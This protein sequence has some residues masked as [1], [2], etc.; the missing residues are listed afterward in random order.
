MNGGLNISVLD[1]WWAEAY[2]GANGFAIGN[3]S[4]HAN[5]DRQDQIDV[6]SLYNVLENEVV[7]LFYDRDPDGVP[8]GWIARQKHALR[9]L[10][11]R[12]SSR[13]MLIDYTL[14]CYLPA[15]GGMTSST[16][17]DIRLLGETFALPPFAQQPWM[18]SLTK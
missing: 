11:W 5:W 10:S 2:D 14:G 3:G 7:G 17:V 6:E 16:G 9:T 8:R 15:A 1:G 18:N 4:E 13:R 12:F